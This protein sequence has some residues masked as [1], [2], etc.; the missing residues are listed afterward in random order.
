MAIASGGEQMRTTGSLSCL[1]AAAVLICLLACLAPSEQTVA[2]QSARSIIP[3]LQEQF[4]L[5]EG[6]VNHALGVLLV[7]A[8]E[9]LPKPEF[10]QLARR[11]PNADL[12]MHAVK[13]QGVVT[14]PLDDRGEYEEALS[15][16]GL[17]QPSQ[18]GP[19]VLAYLAAA[20]YDSE[21]D[22]LAGVLN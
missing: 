10:D 9:R 16:I 13:M 18:F 17:G 12:A 1:S 14:G 4:G 8:R 19:A 22:I 7:F 2:E 21:R 3:Q 15:S 6:Q 20:G 11:L 5:N